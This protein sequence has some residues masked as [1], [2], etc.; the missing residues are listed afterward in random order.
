MYNKIGKEKIMEKKKR[1]L[2][3]VYFRFGTENI[4]WTDMTPAQRQSVS[5]HWTR[6]QW[7]TLA[8]HLTEVINV[9]GDSLD[10]FAIDEEDDTNDNNNKELL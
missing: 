7:Q 8:M 4:C 6:K 2:D 1:D 3:G 9:I 5:E 10:L